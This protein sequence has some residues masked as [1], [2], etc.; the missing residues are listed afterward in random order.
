MSPEGFSDL[1]RRVLEEDPA[2][3]QHLPR[4][5]DKIWENFVWGVFLDQNRL[6]AEAN[7][8]YDVVDDA[9]LFEPSTVKRLGI[10]W[11]ERVH[12]VC[13]KELRNVAGRKR[14]ILQAVTLPSSVEKA[15][16]CILECVSYFETLS[17]ELIR[18]RTKTLEGT[19]DLVAEIAYPQSEAHIF[20]IGLT[21]TILWLQSFGLGNHLC[22]PS[23]QAMNFVEEDLGVRLGREFEDDMGV[24]AYY[25]APFLSQITKVK[26]EVEKS[27]KITITERDIGKAIWYYKSCQ[28]LV[29]SLRQGLKSRLTP[30]V[31]LEFLDTRRWTLPDLAERLTDIDE[32]D[33]LRE[34]LKRFI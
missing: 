33:S 27:L 4:K 30:K 25:F 20:N 6:E 17:P 19:N 7:Y 1:V 13:Q 23:R 15:T 2:A 5:M 28:T 11:G 34:D 24:W 22:P 18:E 32:I 26:E 21:K 14:G 31:L 3:S 16:R 29:A 9:R 8:V 12:E 10:K